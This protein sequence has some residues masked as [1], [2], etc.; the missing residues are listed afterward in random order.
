MRWPTPRIGPDG[1]AITN[2]APRPATTPATESSSHDQRSTTAVLTSDLRYHHVSEWQ[3][4]AGPALCD[5]SH[6]ASEWPWV[7]VAAETL[8][9]DLDGRVEAMVSS[10]RTDPRTGSVGQ[11]GS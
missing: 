7:P 9:R 10:R 5:V 6:F 8:S 1:A 11:E 4:S 3:Q 2:T